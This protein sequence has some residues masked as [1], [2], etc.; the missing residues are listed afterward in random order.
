[1]HITRQI[2]QQIAM[3]LGEPTVENWSFEMRD[4]EFTR[5]QKNIE[6]RRAHDVTV[7]ILRGD[8]L[9]VVRKPDYP[10]NAYRA[11]SGGVHPEES[12]L[13]GAAREAWEETG[14]R[15][16]IEG[17]LLRIHVTFTHRK[18][19]A[20]WT[21]HV[22]VAKLISGELDPVDREEIE[23]ARWVGWDELIKTVNPILVKSGL[24]GLAYRAQLHKRSRELLVASNRLGE[25]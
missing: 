8:E 25:A 21:T 14:L 16:R 17:Y 13:D 9:A 4:E 11:P 15:V 6:L 18:E 22:M 19:K 1:M 10:P 5:L 20:N 2:T 23:S 12:F 3:E 24:G 7:L